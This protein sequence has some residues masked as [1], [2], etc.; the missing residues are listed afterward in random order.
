MPYAQ[1]HYPFENKQYFEENFPADFIA[2]GL[3]QTRGWFYTLHV[4]SSALFEKPAFKNVI[5][6]GIVL[7]EDGQK[8]SKSKKN[9]PDPHKVFEKFGVDAVRF[10]LMNSPVVRSDDLRFSEKAVLENMKNIFLPLWNSYSFFVTYA[11]IDE[12]APGKTAL[13]PSSKLDL[14]ILTELRE[15]IMIVTQKM[16]NYELFESVRGMAAFLQK[17]TNSYIRRS[18]RRFWKSGMGQDKEEAFFTLHTVL[19]NFCQ[20]LAPVA[21]FITEHIYK[22]LT[23]EASVH[24]TDFPDYKQFAD[25][26]GL[27]QEFDVVETIIS[28]GL[29]LRAEKKMKLRQPLLSGEIFLPPSLPSEKI[30][31]ENEEVIKNE[32]NIKKLEVVS[33]IKSLAQKIIKPNARVL[34]PKFGKDM[35]QIIDAAKSGQFKEKDGGAQV[36]EYF[37]EEGTYKVEFLSREGFDVASEKGIV[38][39]LDMS[40]TQNLKNEGFVRE[41][42]RYV[43]EA[44][45]EAGLDV[46]DRIQLVINGTPELL[47]VFEQFQEEISAEVL[48]ERLTFGGDIL[49]GSFTKT[50]VIEEKE[51]DIALAKI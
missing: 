39:A 50:I 36:G 13:Y 17:L 22:N 23:K 3:D 20:V 15:L 4:L 1:N 12:W 19:V 21:P 43:Q 49:S 48:A 16:E 28:L 45:K 8:M 10:T 5:V 14:W 35:Q 32:L 51:I 7:A 46:A 25:D 30:I 9:Y 34:G 38:V 37:L 29:S 2:E 24:L 6:N 31:H 26:P 42:I 47:N 33:D 44:R 40:L 11:N 18:R 27:R 41:L